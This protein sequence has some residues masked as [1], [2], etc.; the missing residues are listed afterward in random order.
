MLQIRDGCIAQMDNLKIQNAEA[1]HQRRKY[2]KI[3]NI[4]DHPSPTLVN[5]L[6]KV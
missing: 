5:E 3:I 6:K 2:A 4:D 1:E